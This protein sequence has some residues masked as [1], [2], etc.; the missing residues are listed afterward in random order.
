MAVKKETRKKET[1]RE[2]NPVKTTHREAKERAAKLAPPEERTGGGGAKRADGLAVDTGELKLPDGLMVEA[3]AR[4]QSVFQLEPVV[5]LI[6]GIALAYVAF[7][8]YLI[9]TAPSE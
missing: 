9:S 8:A 7:I 5:V 3:D 2:H 4:T 1:R 6:L